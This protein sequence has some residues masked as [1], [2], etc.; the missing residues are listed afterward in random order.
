MKMQKRRVFSGVAAHNQAIP[1]GLLCS[2]RRLERERNLYA[3]P[4]DRTHS[5]AQ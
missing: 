1:G 3:C 5:Y 2:I 4:F